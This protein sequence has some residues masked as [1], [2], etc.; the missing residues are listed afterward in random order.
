MLSKRRTFNVSRGTCEIK[1]RMTGTS[2]SQCL[3][4]LLYGVGCLVAFCDW[5]NRYAC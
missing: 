2:F 5:R 4:N 3:G 1:R